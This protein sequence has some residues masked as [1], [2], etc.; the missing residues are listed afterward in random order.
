MDE[1]DDDKVITF[2]GNYQA[3][4]EQ[5][6]K[7]AIELLR[8]IADRLDTGDPS[9]VQF[10]VSAVFKE[11]CGDDVQIRGALW[12]NLQSL[13]H[14][15]GHMNQPLIKGLMK[16]MGKAGPFENAADAQAA[17]ALSAAA[18]R[19][20]RDIFRAPSAEDAKCDLPN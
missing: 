5:D 11:E 6:R 18:E 3:P 10:G 20:K 13:M 15:I 12:G 1:K 4:P 8:K 16:A 14:I 2:G 17:G 7:K 9:S 19:F